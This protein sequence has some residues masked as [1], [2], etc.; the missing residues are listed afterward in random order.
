MDRV[1]TGVAATALLL[2]CVAC[3]TAAQESVARP[4]REK[5]AQ[6]ALDKTRAS[7]V[8][9]LLGPPSRTLWLRFEQREAWGYSYP[10]EYE[11]RVFWVEF[12]ADGVV[13]DVSDS[14]DFDAGQYRGQ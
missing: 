8:R 11:R 12:S 13:R 9:E 14:P 7:E 4:T 5:F 2:A 6:V 3:E 1:A 10:G